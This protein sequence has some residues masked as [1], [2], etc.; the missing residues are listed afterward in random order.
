M[1]EL[2]HQEAFSL[3]DSL[4]HVRSRSWSNVCSWWLP[5]IPVIQ[6]PGSRPLLAVREIASLEGATSDLMVADRFLLRTSDLPEV[7]T[8][9]LGE[10][11]FL[12]HKAAN[13]LAAAER[14]AIS[15]SGSWSISSSYQAGYFAARSILSFLGVTTIRGMGGGRDVLI[16]AWAED[17]QLPQR[18]RQ[19]G[20]PDDR[21][22]QLVVLSEQVTHRGLW[23]IFQRCLRI[24][25]IHVWSRSCLASLRHLEEG[26]FARERNRLHYEP[27]AWPF[28]DLHWPASPWPSLVTV[29][30]NCEDIRQQ[31]ADL[32]LSLGLVL[33]ELAYRL[34]LSLADQSARLAPEAL[35][36][37]SVISSGR[38][39]L[40]TQHIGLPISPRSIAA[41]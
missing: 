14:D 36:L 33:V 1:T 10:A 21:L 32:S 25:R 24:L 7:R 20:D 31:E 18:R 12:L 28:D 23:R 22:V 30:K 13:V 17:T 15:G 29:P 41:E 9:I 19:K 6:P 4:Q 27:I 35:L 11:I 2:T 37:R 39:P 3:E 8:T 34:L 16:D 26:A 38:N 40:L 5:H